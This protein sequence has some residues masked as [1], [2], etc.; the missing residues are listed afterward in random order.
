MSLAAAGR[1]A[2]LVLSIWGAVAVAAPDHPIYSVVRV[3]SVLADEDKVG[4]KRAGLM[5]LPNGVIRWSDVA[6]GGAMDQREIVQDALEDAGLPVTP[7]G[8]YDIRSGHPALRLR[9]TVRMAKL[10]LCARHFIGDAKALSGDIAL[11]IEWRVESADGSEVPHISHVT[12]HIEPDQAASLGSIYR[13]A[14][15]DAA[16]DVAHWLLA[17]RT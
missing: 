1:A 2:C 5:C 13:K 6:T 8:S 11:D 7:L 12:R 3:G 15:G 4:A 17:S 14:L 9:A 10:D 16:G